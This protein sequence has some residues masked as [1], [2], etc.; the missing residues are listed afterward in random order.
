MVEKHF[1]LMDVIQM[2][3][4]EVEGLERWQDFEKF[5]VADIAEIVGI[6]HSYV[7]GIFKK[8]SRSFTPMVFCELARAEDRPVAF[9]SDPTCL[10]PMND[11]INRIKDAIYGNTRADR[12][13][14]I[15]LRR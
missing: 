9:A 11:G 5:L 12:M 10:T 13:V 2:L 1:I 6:H 8:I 4:A 14:C 15:D 3:A 7:E